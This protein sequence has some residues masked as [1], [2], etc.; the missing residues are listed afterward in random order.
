MSNL[1]VVGRCFDGLLCCWQRVVGSG[2]RFSKPRQE[3]QRAEMAMD[4]GEPS[5]KNI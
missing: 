2:K 5:R 1:M 4:G 3:V